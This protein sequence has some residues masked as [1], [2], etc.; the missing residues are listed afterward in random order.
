MNGK[1]IKMTIKPFLFTIL[2]LVIAD[3]LDFFLNVS[4]THKNER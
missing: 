4:E 3:V 2:V 1:D